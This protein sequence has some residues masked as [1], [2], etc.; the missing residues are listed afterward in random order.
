MKDWI[1]EDIA[2]KFDVAQFGGQPGIGTEHMLVKLI[3]RVL[4][5]LDKNPDKSAVI[6]ASIDWSQAF[7]RQDPTLAINK[8]IEIG[9]RSSLIPLLISYISDRKMT[10]KFNGTVSST[11]QLIGGGAQ[12]S[13]LGQI[14]YLVQS[15]GN[16]DCID[17]EDQF[18][19]I[20]DLSVLE[21]VYL[22]ELA[23]KYDI[24]AHVPSDVATDQLFLPTSAYEMQNSLN[25]IADWTTQNLMKLNAQKSSYMIF[26][27]SRTEFATRLHMNKTSLEQKSSMK[28]LGVQISDDLD[29]SANTKEICK[30]SY[31][32]MAI[33]SRLKYVGTTIE[34][35]IDIYILFIRSIA[36][37][38]SVVFHSSLTV[39]QSGNI[40]RIQK[41]ALKIILDESYVS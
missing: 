13:L 7:D 20:D 16:A 9:V 21:L 17:E 14:M 37:Y 29:W 34:D 26:S 15:N 36:E 2:N 32:R 40:E 38:C 24:F 30:K 10:V 5:L 28:L 23:I 1:L 27:R 19:Y 6:A 41:T 39:E 4:F 3:D 12:G 31:A 25:W 18:K 35:L 33:L 8:F 22:A 11:H